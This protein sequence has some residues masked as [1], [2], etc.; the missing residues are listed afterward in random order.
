MIGLNYSP[1]T[2]S[3]WV[4]WVKEG[5]ETV[6]LCKQDLLCKALRETSGAP[7]P[8]TIPPA[9]PP[10]FLLLLHPTSVELGAEHTGYGQSCNVPVSSPAS[11]RRC[12]CPFRSHLL[13]WQLALLSS[14]RGSTQTAP[15]PTP[16]INTSPNRQTQT[17]PAAPFPS[18]PLPFPSIIYLHIKMSLSLIYMRKKGCNNEDVD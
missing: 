11:Q 5:W 13:P 4:V 6:M 2:N 10:A 1:L 12:T 17:P 7:S 16:L 15:L 3:A 18:N 9:I 8:L 14:S